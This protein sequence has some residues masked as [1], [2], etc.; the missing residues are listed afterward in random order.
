MMKIDI[1]IHFSGGIEIKHTEDSW[2]RNRL[3]KIEGRM[4][5]AEDKLAEFDQVLT[6][7]N[8][9]VDGLVIDN[10]TMQDEIAAL[11]AEVENGGVATAEKIQS[12]LDKA[13]AIGGRIK[14]LDDSIPAPTLP[15]G[16]PPDGKVP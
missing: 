3:E 15:A 16:A 1:N 6:D 2:V 7:M 5:M 10:K 8:A 12:L 13:K 14:T 9:N 11:K 4:K